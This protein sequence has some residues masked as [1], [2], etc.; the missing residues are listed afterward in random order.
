M[1]ATLA[2]ASGVRANRPSALDPNGDAR[3]LAAPG[4]TPSRSRPAEA[5]GLGFPGPVVS[6][7]SGS[8]LQEEV[9]HVQSQSRLEVAS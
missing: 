8:F 2:L 6:G 9:S 4:D 7:S 5:A 1:A 3:P